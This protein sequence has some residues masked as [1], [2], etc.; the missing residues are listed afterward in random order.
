MIACPSHVDG[1]LLC[2]LAARPDK[3][4]IDSSLSWDWTWDEPRS[5]ARIPY[6]GDPQGTRIVLR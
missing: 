2:K 6:H 3:V 1:L 4:T 5:L